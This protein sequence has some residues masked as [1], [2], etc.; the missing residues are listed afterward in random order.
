MRALVDVCRACAE[1]DQRE[2]C[3]TAVRQFVEHLGLMDGDPL[4]LTQRQI[5]TSLD[6]GL[7]LLWSPHKAE[8]IR[9]EDITAL[10][11]ANGFH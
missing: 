5:Q 11:G 8:L 7:T 2:M 6:C 9:S 10:Q 4:R 1:G 3:F